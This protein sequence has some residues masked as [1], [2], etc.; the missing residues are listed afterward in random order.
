M[1]E[2]D[3]PNMNMKRI[4]TVVLAC[5]VVASVVVLA[6]KE[7][8]P[9]SVASAAASD[10]GTRLVVYY[11]HGNVRCAT[12][13]SIESYAKEAVATHFAEQLEDG[14]IEWRVVNYEEQG[15]EHFAKRYD[16]VAPC[17]VLSNV[18][19]GKETTWKSLPEVWEHVGDKPAFV[20][21]VRGSV[22]EELSKASSSR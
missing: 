18:V 6:A 11:L 13:E 17:V 21:F 2:K 14:R 8:R 22:D 9:P 12:C 5:F 15:N 1:A 10:S 20:E 4:V 7:L 3:G 16:L 19:N